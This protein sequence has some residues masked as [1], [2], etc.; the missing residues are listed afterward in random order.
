MS[1]GGPGLVRVPVDGPCVAVFTTRRG[2]VSRGP[3]AELNLAGIGTADDAPGD[4]RTNRRRVCRALGL[5]V[6]DVVAG[7]QVHGT[8]VR[9]VMAGERPRGFDDPAHRWP[10]GDGLVCETPGVG[11]AVFGADCLPV[12]LWRRDRAA[13]AAVH[14]G[15][16]GLV[17]GILE[18][19][20]AALGDPRATAA[21]IGP[22]IGPCCYPVG[23]QVRDAFRTRFGEGVAVGEALDLTAAA[24]IALGMAGVAPS[25]I[26]AIGACTS[27]DRERWFSFRRDGGPTG[28]QAGLIWG[29]DTQP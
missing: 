16:R 9:P 5:S 29:V 7:T 14:A 12:L 20:V 10:E 22:G 1:G 6:G 17:G 24:R 13:V 23:A 25:A 3:Y 18:R 26:W 15:W 21:A 8:R 11:L 4:V 19:A 2:G 28:R 27:C